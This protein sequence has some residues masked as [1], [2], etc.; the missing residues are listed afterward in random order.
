MKNVNKCTIEDFQYGS[1]H[2]E[3]CSVS[4]NDFVYRKS[5]KGDWGH[6]DDMPET[7]ATNLNCSEEESENSIA[8]DHFSGLTADENSYL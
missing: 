7:T 5:Y 2:S 8:E 4:D 1:I 6:W 3:I